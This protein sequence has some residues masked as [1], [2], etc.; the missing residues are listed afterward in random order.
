LVPA[1]SIHARLSA[2]DAPSTVAAACARVACTAAMASSSV[3]LIG[4]VAGA[5]IAVGVFYASLGYRHQPAFMSAVVG[6]WLVHESNARLRAGAA[7]NC[8]NQAGPRLTQDDLLKA[9]TCLNDPSRP[10]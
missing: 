8:S 10:P 3:Y 7:P 2:G 4:P 1:A 9:L 6:D 5:V